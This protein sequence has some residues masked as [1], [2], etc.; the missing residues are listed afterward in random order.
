MDAK[1]MREAQQSLEPDALAKH[2]SLEALQ[3]E[4]Y[5]QI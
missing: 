2:R 4:S 5:A 3:P 1:V